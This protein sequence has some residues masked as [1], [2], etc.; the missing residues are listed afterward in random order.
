MK[1]TSLSQIAV[2][3]GGELASGDPEIVIT[4]VSTD[5]RSMP[6]G[7]LFVALEGDRFNAH[8]FLDTAAEKAA[9]CIVRYLPENAEDLPTAFITVDDTLVGLQELARNYRRELD[10]VVVCVTGSNGKTST[11]DFLRAVLEERFNVNATA[12]NFNNHIGLPLTIL[13]TNAEHTCGVWEIGMS[14]PGETEPLAAIARPDVA[15][16]TNI[17][18]AHIEFMKTR[19]A[20]ALEKGMLV[21]AVPAN[22]AVVLNA[23]DD[24]CSSLT[25]RSK[26]NVILAGIECGQVAA[27]NLS[28]SGDGTAFD[29][30]CEEGKFR[31]N[32]PVPGLHMVA[33]A[34]LAIAVGLHLGVPSDAIAQGLSNVAVTA[35]RLQLRKVNGWSFVDDSYNANPDSMMA[36][37]ATLKNLECRGRR[38]AVLGRMA[39]LGEGGVAAHFELGKAAAE[40]F[41]ID[42]VLTVGV[43]AAE[44]ARGFTEAG[45]R[46]TFTFATHAE[47]QRKLETYSPDDLILVKGSRSSA[48]EK[49]IPEVQES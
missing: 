14:N 25:S 13:R 37:M 27:E 5:T 10:I 23:A 12:G 20:I 28:M 6:E 36:A 39:E 32:L 35:G 49:V 9:A 7:A 19:E 33:N 17:G 11:K 41:G 15:V 8:D 2:L 1:P 34:T 47:C 22:G 38:I 29:V 3:S 24:Y 31:V 40:T 45:G 46:E 48:M 44:I 18:T 26:A 42:V 30:V 43:E 4:D 16:V 21:E